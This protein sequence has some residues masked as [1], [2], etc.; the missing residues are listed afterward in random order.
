MRL[1]GPKA[2]A[3]MRVAGRLVA[4]CFALLEEN[5]KPGVT[6][7]ELDQLVESYIEKQGAQPLYKGYRGSSV[8]HP[9]FPGVICASVNHEICHGIPDGR[10]LKEGDVVG[11]D[12]GLRYKG[13]C[14]DACVTFPVGNVS[15][16]VER[17]L[18]IGQE[19]L[20]VGIEAAQPGNYLNDIGR[21]IHDYADS[22][23]VSVVRE[24]GGHGIG[25]ALHE[26]PSVSHVRQPQPGP[27]LR[28]GMTF[29][30]EPMINAGRP[31]W[32]LLNDGWT[33][34]TADGSLSVQFEHTIAITPNGPEILTRLA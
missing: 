22:Q 4:E 13:F 33:V 12:I 5:I 24:W 26:S 23:G 34:I 14:G 1:K 18:A 17:L 21:A 2:L 29:T 7:R 31:E 25:R 3:R 9:P 16:Q 20:R 19:A 8:D 6:L 28:P 27:R 32:I 30:I 10:V 11:I 15:P